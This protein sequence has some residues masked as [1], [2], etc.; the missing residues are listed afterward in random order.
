MSGSLHAFAVDLDRDAVM[1]LIKKVTLDLSGS[2]MSEESVTELR[3]SLDELT[4]S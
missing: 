1:N 2:G 3:K 4:F